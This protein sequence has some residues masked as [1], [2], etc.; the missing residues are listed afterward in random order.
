M[1]LLATRMACGTPCVEVTMNQ[2]VR[3]EMVVRDTVSEHLVCGFAHFK[4]KRAR[5]CRNFHLI[6]IMEAP[7]GEEIEVQS[8]YYRQ[9]RV[10]HS[11][12]LYT[13]NHLA[14][15]LGA[16]HYYVRTALV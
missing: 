10:R 7:D 9:L 12:D 4:I 3:F 1:K 14:R 11:K 8:V 16:P 13:R 15:F 2:R 5:C 6:V